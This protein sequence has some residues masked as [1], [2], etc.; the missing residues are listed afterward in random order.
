MEATVV[1]WN[2]QYFPS[3]PDLFQGFE[4]KSLKF[5]RSEL[6]GWAAGIQ[7]EAHDLIQQSMNQRLRSLPREIKQG[8]T[9]HLDWYAESGAQ[10]V[11][12]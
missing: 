9:D 10:A 3:V 11:V 4:D 1:R 5:F 7:A 12:V 8:K 2:R 6:G